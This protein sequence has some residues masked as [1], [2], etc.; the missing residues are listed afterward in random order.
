MGSA[1]PDMLVAKEVDTERAVEA[2]Q[3]IKEKKR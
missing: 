2:V 1:F 3:R